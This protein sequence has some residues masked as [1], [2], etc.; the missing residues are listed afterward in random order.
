LIR[1]RKVLLIGGTGNLGSS[2][3][4]SK[5]F[6]NLDSPS[7]R[8]LNLLKRSSISRF[9]KNGYHLII[10]CAAI[11]RMKECEKNPYKAIKVN[12]FGTMNLIKE[13][14]NYEV[15]FKKQV[16]L[17]H[18][19]TDGVYP[20]TKGNY[21]ENSPLKPYNVY[22]WTKLGSE[23]IVKTLKNYVLIRTRFFDKSNIRFDTAAT[24]IFTSMIE[25]KNLVKEIKFISLTNFNGIINIGEKKKSDFA[26]YKKF[27]YNIKP[28]K[29]K[30]IVK[31]LTFKIAT[32]AS[33]KLNKLNKLKKKLWKKFR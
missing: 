23:F 21:S 19:S 26:N 24:D 27:K 30:D 18:I 5:V 2:I 13:I 32:D 17:I 12:I 31:N 20:S 28:C 29:R 4:E 6:R 11:S 10:N 7:K 16:K 8:S 15:N 9:L 14:I 3:I 1:N 33:M 25:V 22:G